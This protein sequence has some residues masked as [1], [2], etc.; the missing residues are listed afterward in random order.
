[1][2]MELNYSEECTDKDTPTLCI[3]F[4]RREASP[5]NIVRDVLTPP[6]APVGEPA[7]I[8]AIPL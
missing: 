2:S 3:P 1:M 6:E 7:G 4:L 5:D 8:L